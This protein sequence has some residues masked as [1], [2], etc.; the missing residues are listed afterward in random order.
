MNASKIGIKSDE[1]LDVVNLKM[2]PEDVQKLTDGKKYFP[3]YHMNKKHWITVPFGNYLHT[4]EIIK[5]IDDSYNL[6]R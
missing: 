5:R 4:D 1:I 2:K 6:T 3:A